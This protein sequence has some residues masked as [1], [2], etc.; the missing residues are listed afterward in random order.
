MTISIE[1]P[2][3]IKNQNAIYET[4][5]YVG[6]ALYIQPINLDNFNLWS[7]SCEGAYV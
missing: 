2:D 3:Q 5:E 4:G 1:H 6:F 7:P